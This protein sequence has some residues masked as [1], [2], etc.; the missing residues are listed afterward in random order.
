[1][2]IIAHQSVLTMRNARLFRE[3]DQNGRELTKAH[4]TV[5]QQATKLKEQT[6][7]LRSWNRLLEERVAKQLAEIERIG[8]LQ[9]FLA[10][11]LAQVIASSDENASLLA[12][13]RREVTV[14]FCDLRG[15]TAF[16]E[17]TEPEEVMRV[18]REYHAA[19]GEIIFHYEGTLDRFAGDGIL[20]LF[21]DPIPYPDHTQR[22]VRMA[23]EMRDCVGKL[24]ENWRG[25]GHVLGPGIGIALGYATL[26]QAVTVAW[27][28]RQWGALPISRRGSATRQR[29]ARY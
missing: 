1:M 25:R 9:R 4:D 21:N 10:P 17:S 11:Q 27:N 18:L 19:L 12:S 29:Q 23:V 15:F 6:E 16:T 14:V 26:G 5:Q 2:Q 13:H 7:Q 28:T 8:R 3:I 24:S 20:I 22:A